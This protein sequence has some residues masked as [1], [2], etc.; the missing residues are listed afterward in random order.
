MIG[1][2]EKLLHLD[3][4][5]LEAVFTPAIVNLLILDFVFTCTLLSVAENTVWWRTAIAIATPLAAAVILT[6]FV[7]YLF[8]ATS[9]VYE[10]VLYRK[11]RLNF[12]TTSMLLH[13]NHSISKV[14][15]KRIRN[16]LKTLYNMQLC[17]ENQENADEMEA[18]RTTKDAV[19]LIRNT[20]A[21]SHDSM[22]RRKLKRYGFYRN[23]L[24]GAIYCLPLSL[25]CWGLDFF[26]TGTCNP[27]IL[28]TIVIYALLVVIDFFLTKS[29]AVDYTETLLITFDRLNHYES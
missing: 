22:S 24:G 13:N 14:M 8:R 1:N 16:D 18:R 10:D 27:V 21:D 11:D 9:R 6:R 17:S 29:A 15:K 19:S 3:D 23:F 26:S 28:T 25:L 12:P 4:Y 20:V 2:I 5:D 7:M